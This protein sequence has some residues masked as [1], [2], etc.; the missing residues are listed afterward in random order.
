MCVI[1]NFTPSNFF[2][3]LPNFLVLPK[4]NIFQE[5][6]GRF[7][8]TKSLENLWNYLKKNYFA[9]FIETK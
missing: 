8:M 9:S 6:F 7:I 1:K 2:Q 3:A 5:K 4:N